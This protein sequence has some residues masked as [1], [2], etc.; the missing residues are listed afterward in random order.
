MLYGTIERAFRLID[1]FKDPPIVEDQPWGTA[2]VA[3]SYV[4]GPGKEDWPKTVLDAVA[5][6]REMGQQYLWVDRLC[7]NKKKCGGEGVFD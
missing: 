7:I 4:W 2:Y 5:V 1:C 3:L 6:T